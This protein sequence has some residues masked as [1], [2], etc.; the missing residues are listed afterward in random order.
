MQKDLQILEKSIYPKYQEVATNI[1]VQ[2]AVVKKHSKKLITALDKQG[3]ALH[4]EIDTVIQKLKTWKLSK[5]Q[6]WID[7]KTQSNTPSLK[8]NRSF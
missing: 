4:A 8:S 1:P 5:Y 6:P 2:R 3:E 7:R